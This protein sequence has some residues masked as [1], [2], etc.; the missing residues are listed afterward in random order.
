MLAHLSLQDDG[1]L[2]AKD[3]NHVP[4]WASRSGPGLGSGPFTLYV[5]VAQAEAKPAMHG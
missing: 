2:V 5:S 4:Y 1:N 3:V